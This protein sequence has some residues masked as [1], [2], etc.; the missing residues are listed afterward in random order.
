MY[1]NSLYSSGASSS[2]FPY[3][4]TFLLTDIRHT[5]S[6]PLAVAVKVAVKHQRGLL[7]KS[8]R[9]LLRVEDLRM[10]SLCER[11]SRARYLGRTGIATIEVAAGQRASVVPLNHSVRVQHRHYFEDTGVPQSLGLRVVAQQELDSTLHHPGT[12]GLARM[13]TCSENDSTFRP[14]NLW[15]AAGR[16]SD[17]EQVASRTG[18]SSAQRCA[19]AEWTLDRLQVALQFCVCV[20]LGE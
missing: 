1:G 11:F 17:A 20:R 10:K 19:G 12:D 6:E 5:R 9:H 16:R 14:S 8:A 13:D 3:M 7:R 18:N 4:K 2:L 15:T